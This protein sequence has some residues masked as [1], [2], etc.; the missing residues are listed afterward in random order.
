MRKLCGLDK[1]QK[2]TDLFHEFNDYK[3][4]YC[5][6]TKPAD[7]TPSNNDSNISISELKEIQSSK[8]PSRRPGRRRKSDKNTVSLDI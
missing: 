7:I 2:V 6:L 5:D 4:F 1:N 3:G 8:P